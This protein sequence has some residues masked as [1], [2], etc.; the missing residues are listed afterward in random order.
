MSDIYDDVIITEP[1]RIET[2]REEMAV[3]IYENPDY[4]RDHDFKRETSTPRPLQHTGNHICFLL[5]SNYSLFVA[6]VCS[7]DAIMG[8]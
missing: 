4:V 5:Q 6:A 2:S 3:A 7:S 8:S 1:E